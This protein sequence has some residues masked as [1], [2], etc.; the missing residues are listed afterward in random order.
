MEENKYVI[1]LE[2]P[3]VMQEEKPCYY[4]GAG[5]EK[6]S[7]IR[8]GDSDEHMN[9]YEIYNLISY[10]K[11]KEEDL[12]IIHRSE[13][14][15]LDMELVYEYL[16]KIRMLKP[17]FAKITNDN[18][19]LSKLGV[20]INVDGVY[21]P[22]VAGLLCFGICP[23]LILPQLV[24]KAMVIP[25]FKIGE[26]GELG[27]RF[28]DNKNITGTISDMIKQ[29]MDFIT[30]N[31]KRRV[32]IS[33]DTG[34]HDDKFEYPIEAIREAVINAL[35][36]RDYSQ[37]TESSYISIKMYN[38]RLEISNPGGLYGN[39]TVE[40]LTEV[41]NPPVR[42]KTLIRILEEL[43][44][45]E[46][47][48]SGIATMIMSMR[49]LHLEPPIFENKRGNFN[50]IF[51]NHTLMNK[52]DRK[53]LEKI[54]IQLSENEAL[55]LI[56]LRSNGR[57]TNGD[58]QKINNVNRDKALQELKGLIKKGLIECF[59]IGSGSYYMLRESIEKIEEAQEYTKLNLNETEFKII[60]LLKE[61]AISKLELA[62]KLGY[63]SITGNIKRAVENLIS[64]QIIKYTIPDKPTSKFQKLMLK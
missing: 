46:N 5:I 8:V 57:M 12:R 17:N 23:E 13:L 58:Y 39:L 60:E 59:G 18:I 6:G 11:K 29:T 2:I 49:G 41:I 3:E 43:D 9:T 24:V 14:D 31:M 40:E 30:K 20:I 19:A 44:I 38:D 48:S 7:Y 61:G 55:S 52:D 26:V 21:K 50:V 34:E 42:N 56:Y 64:K 4:R 22:T 35:V 45:I 16:N 1:L 37:Y 28:T 27:E 51:K 32:I 62:N 47:R 10:N 15:D 25:G 53:W 36:H 54:N 63:K 33:P